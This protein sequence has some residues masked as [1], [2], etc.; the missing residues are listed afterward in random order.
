MNQSIASIVAW[1]GVLLFAGTSVRA[2]SAREVLDKAIVAHG[3]S[4]AIK[5]FAAGKITSKGKINIMGLEVALEGET[6]YQL[7]D[8]GKNTLK[9][10]VG[11]MKI[12]VVQVFNAGKVRVTANDAAAPIS[13]AQKD[14]VK[15]AFYLQSVQNLVP[16]LDDK[17]YDLSMID[18]ADKVNDKEVIG[19]LVKAKGHKNVNL[20]FDKKS[21]ILI[22]MERQGLNEAEKEVKQEM[23]FLEH[24][25]FDGILRAVK[26]ELHMDGKTFMEAQ[27]TD[28]KHLDKVDKK[29]FDISD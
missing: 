14:E 12:S 2:E 28:Y 18:N 17:T 23:F 16:L 3:G 10:D 13:D 21:H 1:A 4:D 22:K 24:K 6:V 20:F 7:P 26:S 8:L 15:E 19:V 29:E 5:K 27:V 11:G 9:L 25:K